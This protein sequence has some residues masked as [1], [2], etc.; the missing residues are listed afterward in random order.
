MYV[1][2]IMR[3]GVESE[4]MPNSSSGRSAAGGVTTSEDE[5]ESSS[6]IWAGAIFPNSFSQDSSVRSQRTGAECGFL[7]RN[8]AT[9]SSNQRSRSAM[10]GAGRGDDST[11]VVSGVIVY[12]PGPKTNRKRCQG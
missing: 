2:S 3:D 11:C 1:V 6:S 9:S 5:A 4:T 10:E 12:L 8:F 7:A